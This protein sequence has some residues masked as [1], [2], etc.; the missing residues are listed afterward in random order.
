MLQFP[1]IQIYRLKY[2]FVVD[3][4]TSSIWL[5]P[6]GGFSYEGAAGIYYS[7]NLNHMQD[8]IS[9]RSLNVS[10]NA[11]SYINTNPLGAAKAVRV[12][13]RIGQIAMWTY[14]GHNVISHVS[15]L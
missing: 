14:I 3:P 2:V 1:K 10:L 15:S 11:V 7:V 4:S 13:G 8:A 12:S 5:Q 6:G 9:K